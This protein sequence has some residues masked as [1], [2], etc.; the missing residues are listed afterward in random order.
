MR[1]RSS[2]KTLSEFR[3]AIHLPILCGRGEI[4]SAAYLL[5]PFGITLKIEFS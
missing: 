5:A 1:A 2:S 4:S 3:I